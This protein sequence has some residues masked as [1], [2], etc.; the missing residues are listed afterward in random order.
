MSPEQAEMSGLDIDTRSDIYSLGVLLYELL[1]S[2][3]PFNSTELMSAG[4]AAMRQLLREKEPP[5]PSTCLSTMINEKLTTVAKRRQA[6]APKLIHQIRGD[7][8]WIVMKAL[9][10]DRS[11]RYETA[12]GFAADIE[13]FLK[14]E[15]V[16]A[17]SPSAWYRFQKLV[18]RNKLACGAAAAVSFSVLLGL[19]VSTAL[20]AREKEA[21]QRADNAAEKS[22]QVSLFLENML[23][24]VGP[25]VA[26]GRDTTLLREILDRTAARV[27][28][29]LRNEPEVE[30]EICNTLGEVYRELGLSSNAEEFH[31]DAR[32]LQATISGGKLATMPTWRFR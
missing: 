30:A 3:T 25:A 24:G 2:Q 23:K 18:R 1:T 32:A 21:R 9:E 26:L 27:T 16:L 28:T 29:D 10:K 7:L 8:D 31:S 22:R 12:V 19:A 5:R 13:H 20:Y 6:A 4:L 14:N 15:P 11:R 17:R